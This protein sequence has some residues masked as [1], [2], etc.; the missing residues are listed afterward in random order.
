MKTISNFPIAWGKKIAATAIT[1]ILLISLFQGVFVVTAKAAGISS[2]TVTEI[3]PTYVGGRAP[4]AIS[5]TFRSSDPNLAT[6]S[7]FSS[8]AITLDENW[9]KSSDRTGSGS[10]TFE[11]RVQ[12][13]TESPYLYEGTL[14]N[15]KYTGRTTP[16]MSRNMS[17]SVKNGS[18][19]LAFN[20]KISSSHFEKPKEDTSDNKEET[21]EI[22]PDVTIENV[23]LF[24]KDDKEIHKLD[25][26]TPPFTISILYQDTGVEQEDMYNLIDGSLD[27]FWMTADANGF[28]RD[29]NTKGKISLRPSMG[30]GI[31]RF[32]IDFDDV[33]FNEKGTQ[34]GFKAR[35]L[36]DGDYVETKQI[37]IIP[38][39]KMP[40]ED[41]EE[42]DKD[43][44]APLK[45][46]IIVSH[47][48]YGEDQIQAGS[49]F[50][51]TIDYKNTSKDISLENI[52]MT[53]QPPEDVSIASA[54]NTLHIPS[55]GV[56]ASSSHSLDLKVKPTAKVGSAEI[57][58]SFTYQY[59]DSVNKK[60]EEGTS[61]EKIA[62]PVTQIDR[63]SVD[64]ITE[65]DSY[66]TVGEP[67]YV[68]VG[69][70]NRGKSPTYN[71]SASATSKSDISSSSEHFGNLEAGKSGEVELAITPHQSGDVFGEV[72]I[73]YED[74][75]T[76]QKEIKVD[77]ET[78]VEEPYVPEYPDPGLDPVDPAELEPK[79]SPWSVGFI[80]IGS[81]LAA[82]PIVLYFVQRSKKKESEEIYEDF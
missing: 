28:E 16:V 33:T 57:E 78:Y 45:P 48:S 72:T 34:I 1:L 54:S 18:E 30:D 6:N 37:V 73:Q 67:F 56:G 23:I 39:A 36:I 49:D 3:A 60:R 44:I 25:K 74:E 75:N 24:D 70:I 82:A 26:D 11:I 68:T 66:G 61:T 14:Y 22:T 80:V 53:V 38:Q 8:S 5:F 19:T 17:F 7:P 2:I 58:I 79:T 29:K 27:V 42:K 15:V 13:A 65:Y 32:R 76:N 62:V 52:I 63:F 4:I 46:H 10:T 20:F 47:Y 55:L 71:I 50:N 12:D 31:P 64:P 40:E 59:I 43:K 9:E 35:Y 51:L 21:E 81:L 41:D 69:F 77:F